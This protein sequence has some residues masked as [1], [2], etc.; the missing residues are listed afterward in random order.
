[1][2]ARSLKVKELPCLAC[3]LWGVYHQPF[4]TEAH[5]L[6]LGGKAGQKRRGDEFQIPLC[7]YHHQG[8]L[9]PH[10]DSKAM[11][12]LYGPSYAR[13]SKAFRV[14]FGN[15]DELLKLTNEQ[16]ERAA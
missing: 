14:T 8:H 9:L 16:L 2:S 10:V 15:D 6:T 13:E 3:R 12:A 7:R 11:R 5:H 4:P 1:M